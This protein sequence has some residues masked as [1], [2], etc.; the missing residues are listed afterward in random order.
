M[1]FVSLAAILGA[2]AMYALGRYVRHAK[3]AEAVGS[4]QAIAQAA[5]DYYNGSD[6]SQPTGAPEAAARAMRHF[7]PASRTS[8]PADPA[9]VRG[10]R[11]QS[12]LADWSASPWRELHFSIHQH[13]SYVYSFDSSGTGALATAT[14]VAHGD[15]DGDGNTSTYRLSVAP[16]DKLTARVSANMERINPEE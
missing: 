4:V 6:A 15:L 5:A 11:Y 9:D 14:A 13:Q 1:N 2:L 8:V 10:R 3:T 7:P 12:S 16:D